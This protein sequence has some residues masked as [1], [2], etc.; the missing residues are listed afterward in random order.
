MI[1]ILV[2][3]DDTR[4]RQLVHELLA[5]EGHQVASTGDSREALLM[6]K[7]RPYDVIVTDLKMP[8]AGGM[9]VLA[10]AKEV[11]RETQVVMITAHGT[12]ESAI[13]AIRKGAYDYIQKPFDPDHLVL[14]VNR[15]A[16]HFQA[17]DENKRLSA[18]VE[19]F[20]GDEFVG[21]SRVVL[22]VKSLVEKVAPLDTTVLIQGETGTGKELI[23]RLLHKRSSRAA[24]LFLPVHCGA[25]SETLLESELFGHEKGAFTGAVSEKK[26]LFETA[27]NGTIFLDEID[28]TSQAMQV[29]LLRVLQENTIMRVG[30]ALPLPVNV[31]IIAASNANLAEETAAGRFRKDLFYRLHVMTLGLPALRDRT[32]DIP[33]LARHFLSKYG[34][35]FKKEIKT[36]APEALDALLAYSWPGNVRELEHVV[37]RAVILESSAEITAA[38]LP[39]ELRKERVD[40]FSYI[41]LMKLA[42]MERFLIQRTLRQLDGQKNKAAEALGIDVTTLWRKIKKYNLE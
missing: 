20:R 35:K 1:D 30:S 18:E 4:M 12:V 24:G 34:V 8:Y 25:L 39:V 15:A 29:K 14:L 6:L 22:D 37:E 28:N 26:G 41:G 10:Y 42:D 38:S 23:A 11:K 9:E 16:E 19:R 7:E 33:L 27:S 2:V 36:F 40:P 17:L 3:D 5:G 31:R 13:A 21:S 32:E